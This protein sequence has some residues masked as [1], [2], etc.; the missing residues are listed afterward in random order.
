[1]KT[2]V[3]IEDRLFARAQKSAKA[4]GLTMR[5]LIEQAL[6]GIL[7][8]QPRQTSYELPDLSVG[9]NAGHNPLAGKNWE[10]IR[11]IAYGVD[12]DRD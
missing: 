12:S 4:R 8:V 5:E 6:R 2:T 3:V 10:S 9:P 11:N 7:E 1:M